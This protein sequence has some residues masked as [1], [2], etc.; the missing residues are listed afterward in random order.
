MSALCF[1]RVSNKYMRLARFSRSISRVAE[2]REQ[3]Q[4]NGGRGDQPA[5]AKGMRRGPWQGWRPV[6]GGARLRSNQRQN[7]A[8][9]LVAPLTWGHLRRGRLPSPARCRDCATLDTPAPARQPG[10]MHRERPG[11][12]SPVSSESVSTPMPFTLRSL[13][14]H[15]RVS[16]WKPAGVWFLPSSSRPAV[17]FGVVERLAPAGVHH[18]AASV[19]DRA[20]LRFPGLHVIRRERSVRVVL[21]ASRNVD[22]GKRNHEIADR[23]RSTLCRRR[24]N[25]AERPCASPVCSMSVHLLMLSLSFA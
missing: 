23:D 8:R 18:D 3:A 11:Q 19:R 14:Q 1:F 22:H 13:H 2:R 25:G 20:V 7:P 24:R 9:A 6:R 15:L 4:A 5:C 10:V 16:P 21:G 12:F 17:N